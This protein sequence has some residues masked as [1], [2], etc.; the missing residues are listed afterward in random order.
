[1]GFVIKQR[2]K[3]RGVGEVRLV[4]SC[5]NLELCFNK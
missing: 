2:V 3:V 1:M 4:G 5:S